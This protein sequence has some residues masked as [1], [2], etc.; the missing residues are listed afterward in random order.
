MATYRPIAECASSVRARGPGRVNLI[1][2]H[3]D[4]NGGLALP[5]AIAL[6]VTV[7]A[8]P[9]AGELV[10]VEALDLGERDAFSLAHAEPVPG[11]RAYAR[12]LVAELRPSRGM[13]L[14]IEADLPRGA[15]LS[16]SAALS[17]ALALAILA[18]DGREMERIELARACSRV[19]N[20]WVGASS[21]LLDQLAALFC[22]EGH[23]M[24]IDFSSLELRQV[25]LDLSGWTLA[26]LDSGVARENAASGY[27]ERYAE[28][29]RARELLGLEWL[30]AASPDEVARL[31]EPLAKRARFVLE[32]N[33]RVDSAAAALAEGD[34]PQLGRLLDASH[35]GLR[36]LYEVSTPEV[37]AAVNA[38]KGAGAAG[39]RLIGGGFGG[40]VL[41]LFPPGAA[42]PS[43]ALTV[44]PGG[45]AQLI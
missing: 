29:A 16:S 31:P 27:N 11:W 37:E 41:G 18:A 45:A 15:G 40:S 24:R 21:G 7:V 2:E 4:Y 12:G 38:M 5:F 33:A 28:C 35:T 10:E 26:T 20:D 44:K 17:T 32:E 8:E 30:S 25:P 34:L 42:P 39:A 19:E 14:S 1:G 23:A 6:G 43:A 9:L 22:T 13:R 36:D 3:T